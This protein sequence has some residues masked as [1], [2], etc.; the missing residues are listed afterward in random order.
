VLCCFLLSSMAVQSSLRKTIRASDATTVP[1]D[2]L[3][4]EKLQVAINVTLGTSKR[5]DGRVVLRVDCM[6]R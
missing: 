3:T 1:L 5:H 2:G 6:N 4:S